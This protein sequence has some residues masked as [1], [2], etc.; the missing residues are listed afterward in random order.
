MRRKASGVTEANPGERLPVPPSRDEISRLGETLNEMLA[1][2]ES[3]LDRERGFV[4][5][6]SHELRTPLAILRTELE[7]A[8]REGRSEDELRAALRSA[9]EETDR[10][11][12]LADDLLV[13]ARSDRGTLPLRL[14][15]LSARELLEGVATRF[16]LAAGEVEVDAGEGLRVS[17]DRL[18]LE[19]ALGNLVANAV[20]HGD[21][22]VRLSAAARDGQVEMHVEDVGPGLP[23]AY[24][25]RAFERFTRADS[26]RSGGGAGLG[27]AIVDAIA[28]AHGGRAGISPRDRGAD[29]WIALPA[30][31]EDSSSRDT[32]GP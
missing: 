29:V 11:S 12:R 30:L 23:A 17:G 14:E 13:L 9:S 20:A 22:P 6:A 1:R 19:Q 2:L 21:G 15:P 4:A 7:L 18:R 25:E 28:R 16:R 24:V 8:L 3:A 10:L 31:I 27:L 5:D 26:A 32:S